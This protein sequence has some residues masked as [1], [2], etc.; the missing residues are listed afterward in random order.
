MQS[1]KP[2]S[3]V[4][5]ELTQANF[6][7]L[8]HAFTRDSVGTI[9]GPEVSFSDLIGNIAGTFDTPTIV[10]DIGFRGAA[11]TGVEGDFAA[12]GANDFALIITGDFS[13][14]QGFTFGDTA[15][16]AGIMARPGAANIVR[17]DGDNY[18]TLGAMSDT[19]N[20][21]GVAVCRSADTTVKYGCDASANLTVVNGTATAGAISGAWPALAPVLVIPTSTSYATG[22]YLCVFES[23]LPSANEMQLAITWM[24]MNPGKMY[25]GFAG[26]E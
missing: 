21:T 1:I 8:R 25:P 2:L 26:K 12:P 19:S 6:P 5:L 14:T 7:F 17:L 23:G 9:D 22:A 20:L 10:N 15:S 16:G 3:A 4:D 24:S 18:H 11:I 13:T